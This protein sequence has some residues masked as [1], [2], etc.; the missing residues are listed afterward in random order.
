MF[1][2]SLSEPYTSE[3]NGGFSL[4]YTHIYIF[5]SYVVLYIQLHFN[6]QIWAVYGR[7][8]LWSS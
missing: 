8:S 6:L 5:L 2:T 7:I 4:H 3:S 1:G